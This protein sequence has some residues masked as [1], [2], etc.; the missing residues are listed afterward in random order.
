MLS[1]AE[2]ADDPLASRVVRL[3]AEGSLEGREED[4][5]HWLLSSL[6]IIA[7]E[8]EWYYLMQLCIPSL[9]TELAPDM[10]AINDEKLA[11]FLAYG[12][13]I[14]DAL[15]LKEQNRAALAKRLAGDRFRLPARLWNIPGTDRSVSP[16]SVYEMLEDIRQ[17]ARRIPKFVR[18]TWVANSLRRRCSRFNARI[19]DGV[20][21]NLIRH[22]MATGLQWKRIAKESQNEALHLRIHYQSGSL[23]VAIQSK[24]LAKSKRKFLPL[25]ISK[26]LS[27]EERPHIDRHFALR[28]ISIWVF[29]TLSRLRD[30]G[31]ID[32]LSELLSYFYD[33]LLRDALSDTDVVKRLAEMGDFP[34]IVITVHGTFAQLPFAALH[35]GE[36]YL[37]ER[38]NVVQATPLF[39]DGDFKEGAMDFDAVWGGPRMPSQDV[40]VVA[41][42]NEL[43]QIPYEIEDLRA[44]STEIPFP[45]SIWPDDDQDWTADTMHWLFATDGIALLSAHMRASS[46]HASEA[47]IVAPSGLE[48]TMQE[49]L[50]QGV[51]ASLLILSG[52]Q[53]SSFTD[54]FAPSESSVVSLCRSAGAKSVVSTLWP[55][56]DYPARLYNVAMVSGVNRGLSRAAAHGAAL[57][58]VMT[59]SANVGQMHFGERLVRR[60]NMKPTEIRNPD[61]V[62]SHPYYWAC[63]MLTGAWR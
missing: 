45:L 30:K 39:A 62:L 51:T 50:S 15:F 11:E 22:M 18:K 44:S 12:H 26:Y 53:S 17:S 37:I 47:M 6:A 27:D 31:N 63:F 2:F 43:P 52:C 3:I 46:E 19:M 28:K 60:S 34:T 7:A 9:L 56:S 8:Q 21:I 14:N 59:A 41:G 1:K 4:G 24:G 49:A 55:T 61:T 42:G 29:Q 23:R 16:D 57:R 40:R 20:D 36:H 10:P 48:T 5:R 25:A 13:R 32:E 54:W 38:F 58:H 33:L 35:D